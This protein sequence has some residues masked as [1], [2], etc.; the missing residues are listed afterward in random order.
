MSV[1]NDTY[2][3]TK[4][5]KIQFIDKTEINFPNIGSDLLQKWNI[6]GNKKIIQPRITD[7]IRS[8]KTNSPTSHL[9]AT[10]LPP[11]GNFFCILKLVQIITI[12]KECFFHSREQT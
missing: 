9:G 8:T 6:K 3:L 2:N 7:F 11:I 5:D 10:S 4:H 1:G 12:M